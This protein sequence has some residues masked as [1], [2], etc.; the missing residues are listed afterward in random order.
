MVIL[1]TN[2]EFY[3]CKAI[4]FPVCFCIASSFLA[5]SE[6]KTYWVLVRDKKSHLH[7]FQLLTVFWRF[8]PFLSTDCVLNV[9]I[10]V[11]YWLPC[12]GSPV[13]TKILFVAC[14][15]SE[16]EVF[17][18]FRNAYKSKGLELK[19]C[20]DIDEEN[21]IH[22]LFSLCCWIKLLQN[23]NWV[24][25]ICG[26]GFESKFSR[27]ALLLK[28][29]QY[30]IPNMVRSRNDWFCLF[31][32]KCVSCRQLHD[33]SNKRLHEG[34]KLD[35]FWRF[36]LGVFW[37]VLQMWRYFSAIGTSNNES[38]VISLQCV[39]TSFWFQYCILS[40]VERWRNNSPNSC[41]SQLVPFPFIFQ[42]LIVF[43]RST[44]F[45][46]TGFVLNVFVGVHYWACSLAFLF[47]PK[48]CS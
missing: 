26:P 48:L 40:F 16:L 42:T 11:C 15:L 17:W 21:G 7:F 24:L 5:S 2:D 19:H 39:F 6:E 8:T 45:F 31:L 13:G 35:F 14:S 29:S 12:N 3:Q 38:W 10:G 27:L 32:L 28:L 33:C 44:P 1:I 37:S 25:S 22:Y 47:V 36:L 18:F 20:S 43:W 30:W 41:E 34:L 46:R 9:L 23:L 4:L